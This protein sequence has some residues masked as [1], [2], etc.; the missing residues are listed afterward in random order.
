MDPITIFEKFFRSE[1]LTV[2]ELVVCAGNKLHNTVVPAKVAF[3]YAVFQVIPLVG[4]SGQARTTVQTRLLVDLKIVTKFPVPETVAPAVAAIDEHFQNSLTFDY[5][6]WRISV[7]NE[8][9]INF[10]E[11]GKIAD[12]TLIHRG[13]TFKAWMS[14]AES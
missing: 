8:M 1:A 11:R 14:V 5:D 6:G 12:E 4:K 9:P 10:P 2:P 13:V 3:P 7:R